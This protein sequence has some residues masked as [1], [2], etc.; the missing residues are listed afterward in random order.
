MK[1]KGRRPSGRTHRAEPPDSTPAPRRSPPKR[2]GSLARAAGTRPPRRASDIVPAV[3]EQVEQILSEVIRPLVEAD[4]GDVE[5]TSIDQTRRPVEVV[6]T[7]GGAY[8]GC[9]GTPLVARDVIEPVL[10][11]ALGL[12]VRVRVVARVSVEDDGQV[13]TGTNRR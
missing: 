4:G 13:L 10:A 8:R 9:P 3:N 6:L 7:F 1:P 2:S 11:K 12:E 5:L